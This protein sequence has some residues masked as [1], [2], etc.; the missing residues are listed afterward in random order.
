M[1]VQWLHVMSAF[2]CSTSTF[3]TFVFLSLMLYSEH[4]FLELFISS[5]RTRT[6]DDRSS[7]DILICCGK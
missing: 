1:L 7:C 6:A 4:T 3:L 2:S 5:I